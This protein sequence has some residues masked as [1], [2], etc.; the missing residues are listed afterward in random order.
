[1]RSL[2]FLSLFFIATIY[3]VDIDQ[4][5][6]PCT[7]GPCIAGHSC[8]AGAC[9]PDYE[10]PTSAPPKCRDIHRHP[11]TG[12]KDCAKLAYLCTDVYFY[13]VMTNYC[14]ATCNRCNLVGP[15]TAS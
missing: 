12:K 1:M 4:C 9:C 3:A 6:G 5:S 11:A 14:S 2:I 8:I 7:Y 15:T 13:D 10:V